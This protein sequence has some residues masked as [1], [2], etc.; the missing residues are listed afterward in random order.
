[1]CE[2]VC[3]FASNAGESFEMLHWRKPMVFFS[4]KYYFGLWRK[5]H[6][7][8]LVFILTLKHQ[9]RTKSSKNKN[10]KMI[11]KWSTTSTNE[12]IMILLFTTFFL[13]KALSVLV[14]LLILRLLLLRCNHVH[15][16]ISTSTFPFS[17]LIREPQSIQ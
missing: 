9:A 7:L 15:Y 13:G 3:R 14:R 16:T 5:M 12:K 6:C 8:L 11:M 4:Y 17:H 1:V 2:P 10:K